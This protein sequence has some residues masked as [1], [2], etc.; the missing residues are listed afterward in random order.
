MRRFLARLAVSG[1][2]LAII[3]AK[4]DATAGHLMDLSDKP[5]IRTTLVVLYRFMVTGTAAENGIL[6]T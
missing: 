2:A 1:A 6:E 5:L 4:K 3:S